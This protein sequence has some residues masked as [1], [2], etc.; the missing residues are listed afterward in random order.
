MWLDRRGLVVFCLAL[1]AGLASAETPARESIEWCNIW[2]AGANQ[3]D[4]PNVLLIG[5]S[6]VMS[7][8][9]R[10]ADGLKDKAFCA[11]LATSK[12]LGDPVLLEEVKLVLRQCPF[13]VVH[14]NNG[15]HGWGYTEDQ[16]KEAFPQLLA[17]LRQYAPKAK[18]IW[19]TTTPVRQA[20]QLEQLSPLT[21]RVQA[22]NE[23]AEALVKKAGIPID[24]LYGRVEKRSEYYSPDG[25]HFNPQGV[26]AL[27]EQVI[28]NVQKALPGKH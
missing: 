3:T 20:K 28:E 2:V 1:A 10:V 8:Y 7:Y 16:Y 27:A 14:F 26:T 24:N 12:S 17:V 23:I 15:L 13:A 9:Q 25:V 4:L 11:R 6:I 21:Q 18:L 22:R 5:D 19:A